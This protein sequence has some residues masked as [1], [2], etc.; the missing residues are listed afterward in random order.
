MTTHSFAGEVAICGIGATEFSKKSGRSEL[1]LA[2]EAVKAAIDDAGIA[3][4]QV[5]G[6]F[7]DEHTHT[8]PEGAKLNAQSVVEGLRALKDC[9]LTK[10][11]VSQPGL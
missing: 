2:V 8:N 10:C 3:P 9:A 4:E 5:N 7:A 6:L 1:R 11:L